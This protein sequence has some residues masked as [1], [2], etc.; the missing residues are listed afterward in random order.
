M[1]HLAAQTMSGIAVNYQLVKRKQLDR[2]IVYSNRYCHQIRRI[3]AFS[4]NLS[5]VID[6]V[7][8]LK[9]MRCS[10]WRLSPPRDRVIIMKQEV[11]R[12]LQLKNKMSMSGLGD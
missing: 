11:P 12:L 8:T 10:A 5:A 9:G 2:A 1:G 7:P 4:T 6:D 3:L